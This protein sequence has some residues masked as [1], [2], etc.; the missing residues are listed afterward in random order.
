MTDFDVIYKRNAVP[1]P[2]AMKN[3]ATEYIENANKPTSH[4]TL[5]ISG[6][7]WDKTI[8]ITTTFNEL[9]NGNVAW[10]TVFKN[11]ILNQVK[12]NI[13]RGHSGFGA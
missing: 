13:C 6:K 10:N 4:N 11:I 7:A 8:V 2:T 3:V 1:S 5:S 12:N 9:T